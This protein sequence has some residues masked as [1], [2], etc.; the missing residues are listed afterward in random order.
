MHLGH[1]VR[2]WT[3]SY[4]ACPWNCCISPGTG[5]KTTWSSSGLYI[6]ITR[7]RCRHLQAT[8]IYTCVLYISCNAD[9]LMSKAFHFRTLK[10]A[11]VRLAWRDNNCYYFSLPT[12]H[13]YMCKLSWCAFLHCPVRD[14]CTWSH[15]TMIKQ[16]APDVPL[17]IAF[18]ST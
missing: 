3:A 15:K 2:I 16:K 13:Y 11:W 12:N 1:S 7:T 6:T 9:Y 5:S 8:F 18:G 10:S 4:W 17:K 14:I